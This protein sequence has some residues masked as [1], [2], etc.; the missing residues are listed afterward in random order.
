MLAPG[1]FSCQQ[2]SV[3][4]GP[5]DHFPAPC[6][7]PHCLEST[8]LVHLVSPHWQWE[9]LCPGRSARPQ[10][11]QVLLAH[12]YHTLEGV[13]HLGLLTCVLP[14]PVPPFSLCLGPEPLHILGPVPFCP[15]WAPEPLQAGVYASFPGA[16]CPTALGF[17]QP[18]TARAHWVGACPVGSLC[19]IPAASPP[20]EGVLPRQLALEGSPLSGG[21]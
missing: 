13:T 1:E 19:L 4:L 8:S 12:R 21:G 16:D 6:C 10:R 17:L 11:S 18:L 9:P 3:V 5:P 14:A 7:L 20:R 15:C 2:H